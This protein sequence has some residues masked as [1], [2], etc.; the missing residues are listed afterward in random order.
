MRKENE[1]PFC[2][3]P[4]IYLPLLA[5]KKSKLTKPEKQLRKT[6]HDGTLPIDSALAHDAWRR[7]QDDTPPEEMRLHRNFDGGIHFGQ[8]PYGDPSCYIGKSQEEDGHI[9]IVGGPGSHK[10]TGIILPTLVTWRGTFVAIDI[11]GDIVSFCE[12][13]RKDMEYETK[14]IDFTEKGGNTFHYA[15]FAKLRNG[16]PDE[17]ATNARELALSI[18]P[19]PA[20][21]REPFWIQGAQNILTA[22]ILYAFGNRIVF[23]DMIQMI[24]TT[25]ADKLRKAIEA[26]DNN[27]AKSFVNQFP[28]GESNRT[29]DKVLWGCFNDMSNHIRV[30]NHPQVRKVFNS[31]ESTVDWHEDMDACFHPQRNEFANAIEFKLLEEFLTM[32][33][34]KKTFCTPL[35]KM[36]EKKTEQDKYQDN[37]TLRAGNL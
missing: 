9:L 32:I 1:L 17:L 24:L 5:R 7:Q 14:V 18:I 31:S 4:S 23:N 22:V 13:H 28:C 36:V 8:D 34:T 3:N 33:A 12:R 21:I 19:M 27:E 29:D 26:S 2:T 15:P 6:I 37:T 16:G 25:P 10:T 11:K 35:H 20:D 30:F